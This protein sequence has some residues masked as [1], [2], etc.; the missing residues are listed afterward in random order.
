MA[1]QEG[2][3]KIDR[4]ILHWGWFTNINTAHL[5]LT[6]LLKANYKDMVFEG[7]QILAGSL[8]TSLPA[9]SKVSGLSIQQCR[10]ALK[11]LVSTREITVKTY[12]K[13]QVITI[14]NYKQYQ[15][16]TR[17]LTGKQHA[18][19]VTNVLNAKISTRKSTGRSTDNEDFQDAC[20][21]YDSDECGNDTQHDNQHDVQQSSNRQS[22]CNQHQEKDNKAG[23]TRK[24]RIP[25]KSPTGGLTPPAAETD[26]PERGTAGFRSKS[27]LLLKAE[28]GTLDDIPEL[29]K[30]QFK[31]FAEYWRYRN[32]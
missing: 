24:K 13:Y 28:E 30:G 11:H 27:H 17:S 10:T 12:P 8:A 6:L 3:I 20:E 32:Q 1:E 4:N 19:S 14:V 23:N 7:N 18:D 31:T 25:P 21:Y 16:P 15:E 26:K 2:Y 29:Y 9:L 22:T 5:F